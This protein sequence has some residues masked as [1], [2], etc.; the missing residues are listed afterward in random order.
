MP[1]QAIGQTVCGPEATLSQKFSFQQYRLDLANAI[2]SKEAD[3]CRGDLSRLEQLDSTT[4]DYLLKKW[5]WISAITGAASSFLAA[6]F[7]LSIFVPLLPELVGQLLWAVVK[8]C[9]GLSLLMF[10]AAIYFTISRSSE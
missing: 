3:M 9:M 5:S 8:V 4:D 10:C 2:R 7:L 1:V 6:P